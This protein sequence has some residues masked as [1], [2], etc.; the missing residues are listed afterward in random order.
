MGFL[1]IDLAEL[2]IYLQWVI[3]AE[4]RVGIHNHCH[5]SWCRSRAARGRGLEFG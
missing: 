4:R 3:R 2:E 1:L 5:G